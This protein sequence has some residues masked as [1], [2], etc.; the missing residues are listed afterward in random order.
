[1]TLS[2]IA[3]LK[4]FRGLKC[5]HRDTAGIRKFLLWNPRRG[6]Q[7]LR[8][9]WILLHGAIGEILLSHIINKLYGL[10]SLAFFF[11]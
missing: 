3:N 9:F 11:W 10:L 2:V 4:K 8:L 1:M 6:I 7:N 5:I